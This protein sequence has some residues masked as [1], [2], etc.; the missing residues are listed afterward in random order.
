M[1]L[2]TWRHLHIYYR[3]SLYIGAKLRATGTDVGDS[4]TSR[5][6]K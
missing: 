2:V 6:R 1:E 4:H 3:T 5:L